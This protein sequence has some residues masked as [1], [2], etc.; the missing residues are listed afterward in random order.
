MASALAG[1]LW[2]VVHH[3]RAA[4]HD[5][6]F[7]TYDIPPGSP[8]YFAALRWL[9]HQPAV[10]RT[11]HRLVVN[12]TAP[13]DAYYDNGG[14]GGGGSGS[15]LGPSSRGETVDPGS[16]ERASSSSASFAAFVALD[17][18]C[19]DGTRL[20]A[21]DAADQHG[22]LA[23]PATDL[24]DAIRVHGAAGWLYRAVPLPAV[25]VRPRAICSA[26]PERQRKA[27]SVPGGS[28]R[29]VSSTQ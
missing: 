28:G 8:Q 24:R 22:L 17:V 19:D 20:S 23:H 7:S 27:E 26:F 10:R 12:P 4:L 29:L 3:L 16:A 1:L 5:K 25:M 15:G 2:R 11:S 13:P 14:G 21:T 6:L 18:E 9:H